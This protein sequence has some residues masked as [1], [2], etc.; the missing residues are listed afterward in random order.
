[1][2]R[3][4]LLPVRPFR[5]AN[6]TQNTTRMSENNQP[7]AK[8]TLGL[9]GLTVN[10]M[11]LIAPGAF[12]WLTFGEQLLYGQP[13]AAIAMWFGIFVALLLCFATAISYAELSKL[14]PGAGSSYFF[15]EQAF[16][17]KT[18][19]F[20]FARIAKFVVGWASHLYY[21]VY[22]GVMVAVTAIL[23]GY[24]AGQLFPSVFNSAVPS[25]LLMIVFSILFPFAVGYIA[26]SGVNA[27][28]AVNLAIN[29]V[30]ITALIVFTVIAIGYRLNHGTE[31][32]KGVTL[33]PD[34]FAV[35]K[36]IATQTTKDD[37][38]ND[39]TN[40]VKD[41]DGNYVYEKNSDGTDKD[42]TLTWAPDQAINKGS[43]PKNPADTFQFHKSALSVI[44]P[45]G[46]SFV[47]VQACVA[48]LILVGFE[49]IT[50]LGEEA[51]DAKRDLPRAVLL[52][53][54]IQGAFCYL[55]E[56]FGANFFL[57][58][59]YTA[60]T[61]SG[62]PAPIGDMMQIVGT[63]VFGSPQAGWWFMFVQAITVF[64]ALIGTTLACVNTGV[65]VT[66]A[67][68]RDEEVPA[69]F[70]VLHGKNLT[71][72]R[73]IWV[74]CVISAIIGIFG[75]VLYFCGGAAQTDDTVKG[76]PHNIWYSF[77]LFPHDAAANIPQSL[78]VITLISN[79]GT[80]L[81]YMMTCII[82]MIAYHEHHAFHG[83]KHV[84]VPVFGLLANLGCL[85]FY[86]VGPFSVAGM[87]WK[88]PY[89]A[90]GVA[91]V[92]GIYGAIYFTSGSRKK[93]KPVLVRATN[94]A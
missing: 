59:G 84:F 15:A 53:L 12:L 41:K 19:A 70:G 9:T 30:Q 5:V 72:H 91:A 6:L 39:V 44:A 47:M 10:A 31:G 57:N 27:S 69:H 94:A 81:L 51:K 16:L 65:R 20:R 21:W 13:M 26:Y 66:Y 55:F 76:L 42:Y 38:G 79:F 48:I 73:A 22:P 88:E 17:S 90:L 60:T 68:G 56:Y 23:V 85:L 36:V 78:L 83:F 63:W 93:D 77:G 46:F 89:I 86:L 34:G 8:K 52:S 58:S 75:V 11:A 80:F 7:T 40:P 64:L 45:H 28:T 2:A 25:P 87:S 49:S 54:V 29:V 4:V 33:N 37:K 61:G 43:D 71:P 1:M 32:S 92:W 67:M 14:Y 82:A 74:L 62:S 35:T 18:K 50:S 24:L 3:Q